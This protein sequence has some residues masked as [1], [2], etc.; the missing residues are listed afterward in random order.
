MKTTSFAE[1]LLEIK[2]FQKVKK[3]IFTWH[4]CR[5]INLTNDNMAMPNLNDNKI[6]AIT[7]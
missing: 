6:V 7:I 5:G 4:L 3:I 1:I 2:G